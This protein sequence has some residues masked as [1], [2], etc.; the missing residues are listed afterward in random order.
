MKHKKGT[1]SRKGIKN[2][3]TRKA[4]PRNVWNSLR[5]LENYLHKTDIQA[6]IFMESINELR[7]IMS[8]EVKSN[9]LQKLCNSVHGDLLSALRNQK[10]AIEEGEVID[11]KEKE[12]RVILLGVFEVLADF[13]DLQFYKAE[14]ERFFVT[15]EAAGNFEFDEIPEKLHDDR[16]QN[17]E[18]EVLMCGWKIGDKVIQKQKVFVFS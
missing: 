7:E 9:L 2:E 14:G 1:K 15:R 6:N 16:V 8:F 5:K 17:I 18:V 10:R 11:E 12:A 4:R 3:H 13:L